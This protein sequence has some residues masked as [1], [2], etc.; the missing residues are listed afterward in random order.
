MHSIRPRRGVRALVA[1]AAAAFLLAVTATPAIAA[2]DSSVEGETFIIATDTTFAP[3]GMRYLDTAGA[4][5]TSTAKRANAITA[6]T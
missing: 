6:C 2:E 5:D 1:G 3:W 4:S